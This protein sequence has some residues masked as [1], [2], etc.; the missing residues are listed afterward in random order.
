MRAMLLR[1]AALRC[2]YFRRMPLRRARADSVSSTFRSLYNVHQRRCR[3]LNDLRR[4]SQASHARPAA[5]SSGAFDRC[6]AS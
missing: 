1:T 5:P 3:S 2:G 6:R 4:S